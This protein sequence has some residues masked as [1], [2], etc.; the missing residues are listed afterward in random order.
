MLCGGFAQEAVEDVPERIEAR[1]DESESLVVRGG[2]AGVDVGLV[3]DEVRF[4]V[5][6]VDVR[7]ALRSAVSACPR[8]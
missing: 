4:E 5:G 6:F 1:L 2:D 3:L 8:F 7:R